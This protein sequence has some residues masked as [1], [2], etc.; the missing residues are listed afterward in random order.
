MAIN[1]KNLRRIKND[2]TL[3]PR[4]IIYGPPKIGKTTLASEFPNPVFLQVEDGKPADREIDAFT[5]DDGGPLLTYDKVMGSISS[6][7][8]EDHDFKTV[9]LDSLDKFEPLVWARVCK[10]NN[11]QSIE[12]PG[13]GKGYIATDRPWR[14]FMEGNDSYPGMNSLRRDRGMT[15]VLIGHSEISRFDDPNTSSYSK[16]DTRLHK[17]ANAL[18]QDDSD[19]ILFINQEVTIK[20][21]E[22]GFTQKRTHAEGGTQRWIFAEA[23]ASFVAGNRLGIPARTLYPRSGGY[24]ALAPYLPT[25]KQMAEPK[26][27]PPKVIEEQKPQETKTVKSKG[28]TDNGKPAN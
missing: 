13:Y 7:Y 24:K 20:T 28:K 26:P 22:L 27:E 14:E 18:I 15:I 25:H 6:L 8:T 23:R 21:E 17:R 19:A 1:I 2:Q 16:Y 4:I 3:P 11:W 10:D 9:V 12:D 5:E